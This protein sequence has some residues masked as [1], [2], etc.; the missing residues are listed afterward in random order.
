MGRVFALTDSSISDTMNKTENCKRRSLMNKLLPIL[1]FASVWLTAC[2]RDVNLTTTNNTHTAPSASVTTTS[3]DLT[4]PNTTTRGDGKDPVTTPPI[5]TVPPETEP[6]PVFDHIDLRTVDRNNRTIVYTA[7]KTKLY[8]K[9][10]SIVASIEAEKS[11]ISLGQS[12]GY[13]VILY[14]DSLCLT[15]TNRL[16]E[17]I[18]ES[19]KQMQDKLGGIYYPCG[20]ILVAIDAGHQG[21]AMKEKEPLGPGATQM[22]A[23][24]SSGTQGVST[25]IAERELN[26]K[27][28]LL[29]RDELISRGY[30]VLMIRESQ[31]VIISNAQRAQ[32]S[33]AYQADAFVRIH[34]NGS[35]DPQVRGA[36][37]ICQTPENPYNGTLYAESRRL[38]DCILENYCI[39]SGI[40]PNN[41]WE[42]DTMTGINWAET[43]VTIVEM[44]YMSNAEED[45][46][47]ATDAF[48]KSAAVGIANGLDAFFTVE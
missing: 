40:V 41:V 30:S 23:M 37:T 18:P 14:Q 36:M 8:R 47:M 43:P 2:T 22:K 48:R 11:L 27:V 28:A 4:L 33:N 25:R 17:S 45:E 42:T 3:P 5:V 38:S 35:T 21:K 9:D 31:D 16:T 32:I 6:V 20:E 10:G 13:T 24:V 34:A 44:G 29:L 26:L 19:A 46:L 15:H 12:Q 1:L 7:Q 39:A